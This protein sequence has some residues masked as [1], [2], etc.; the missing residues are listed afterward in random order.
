MGCGGSGGEIEYSQPPE[1]QYQ[2][3][4]FKQIQEPYM[5]SQFDLY[6]TSFAPAIK[7]AGETAMEGIKDPM[8]LPEN[9][10][11]T[12]FPQDYWDKTWQQSREK[13]LAEYA[14]IERQTSRRVAATGGIGQ[15]PAN[16]LFSDIEA[17]KAKSIE[18]LAIDQAINQWQELKT[19]QAQAYTLKQNA[20]QN[21]LNYLQFQPAFNIPM[22]SSQAYITPHKAGVGE[23]LSNIFMPYT[24]ISGAAASRNM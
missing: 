16:Q 6:N 9:W 7:Q 4:L 3:D 21:A 18:T 23:V 19:A 12:L 20:Y 1:Y 10:K 22:P 24:G 8:A 14:P 17:K 15:G 2:M 11:D 13:T 5:R